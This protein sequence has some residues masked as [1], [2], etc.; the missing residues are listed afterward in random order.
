MCIQCHGIQ[1]FSKA[2][3]NMKE[4]LEKTKSDPTVF[5]VFNS[6][7]IAHITYGC[8][9]VD[10]HEASTYA[11]ELLRNYQT[12][13]ET[14]TCELCPI[15]TLKMFVSN[16]M[17]FDRTTFKDGKYSSLTPEEFQKEFI[18]NRNVS[19]EIFK[20]LTKDGANITSHVFVELASINPTFF[21]SVSGWFSNMW[22]KVFQSSSY[23][24]N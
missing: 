22:Q 3:E 12:Y 15:E 20:E 2:S 18:T 19:S 4:T 11:K 23:E 9:G 14:N 13:C 7:S 1:Q 17:S 5:K 6:T 24:S 21:Q 8:I 16:V 10:G